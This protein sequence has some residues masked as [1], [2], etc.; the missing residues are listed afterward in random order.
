MGVDRVSVGVS[1][2]VSAPANNSPVF[3]STDKSP[4]VLVTGAI[5]I[6]AVTAGVSTTVS[7]AVSTV[8]VAVAPL[9]AGASSEIAGMAA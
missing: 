9:E 8:V 3:R 6:G 7:G 4:S 2:A 5:A 1:V